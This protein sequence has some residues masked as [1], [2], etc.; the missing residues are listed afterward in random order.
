MPI[1]RQYLADPTVILKTNNQSDS[2]TEE[3]YEMSLRVFVELKQTKT[4]APA[5][6][7]DRTVTYEILQEEMNLFMEDLKKYRK[8]AFLGR[9][10]KSASYNEA[11]Q[12]QAWMNPL[13][14]P[15]L[16]TQPKKV[17]AP[18]KTKIGEDSRFERKLILDALSFKH[19]T[20]TLDVDRLSKY[21]IRG[22]VKVVWET[23]RHGQQ[24][25]GQYLED[26]FYPRPKPEIPRAVVP[27]PTISQQDQAILDSLCPGLSSKEME[28][29]N[30]DAHA[31][32][33][34]RGDGSNTPF[35]KSFLTFLYS[36]N[37]PGN[38]KVGL[39][40]VRKKAE[41]PKY[42]K[43]YTPSFVVRSVASQLLA[44]LNRHYKYGTK[45]LS[46]KVKQMIDKG[47]LPGNQATDLASNN[48]A[49]HIFMRANAAAD[50]LG[51]FLHKRK[52]LHP[53]SQDAHRL[54]ERPAIGTDRSDTDLAPLQTPGLLIQHL[55]APIAPKSLDDERLRGRKRKDAGI[56]AAVRGIDTDEIRT[57]INT[58]RADDF[59]PRSY[60]EE[61]YFMRGSIK[62]DGY[63]LQLLAFKVR[64]LSSVKYKR[65]HTDLLPDRL[66]TTT[67][68][69]H[70][71]L[72]EVHNVFRSKADVERL[73]G[74]TD[75]ETDQVS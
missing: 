24:L 22:A 16:S 3:S 26:L 23:K 47:L 46:K 31:A 54:Q 60:Q 43:E 32:E 4:A 1:A 64:E 13:D 41:M 34:G 67:A 27:V 52:E 6:A 37:H 48:P 71:Y 30:N 51:A 8:E 63:H 40:K 44:E 55:I 35:T 14:K 25:I 10:S 36:S 17:L 2:W 21:C 68:G 66:F 12:A 15:I 69:T 58:L 19:P 70:D 62:T 73:L 29:E 75:D 45:E 50:K 11:V 57:H 5:S 18:I 65:Y 53:H 72:S 42:V 39:A 33:N 61:G 38:S 7:E 28:D 56:T 49:I 74:Y 20:V 59:D 9:L